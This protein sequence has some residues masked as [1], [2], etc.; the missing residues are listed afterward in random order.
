MVRELLEKA[1]KGDD[2]VKQEP[3]ATVDVA[4]VTDGSMK[5]YVRPWTSCDHYAK[6][7]TDMMER[8]R[9]AMTGAQLK[10]SV[11]LQPSA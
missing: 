1:L 5:L 9:D 3:S 6:F 11:S 2:R 4:E 8:I 10:F 7:V